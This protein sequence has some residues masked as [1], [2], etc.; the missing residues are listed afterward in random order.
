MKLIAVMSIEQYAGELRQIFIGHHVPVFSEIPVQG[1]KSP[2]TQ[3]ERDNWFAHKPVSV[4]S[5]LTFAFT[6]ADMAEELMAA[7]QKKSRELDPLN[8][9][10][11]FQ[12]NV[13]NF[14]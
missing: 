10:R 6:G 13:E 3:T 2:S 14:L 8:P 4:Y 9:V 1:Y 12:L 11:A 5:H 7:I